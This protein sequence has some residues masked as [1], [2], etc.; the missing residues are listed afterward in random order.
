MLISD[1]YAL[2]YFNDNQRCP[3]SVLV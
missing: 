3:F 2:G 1:K